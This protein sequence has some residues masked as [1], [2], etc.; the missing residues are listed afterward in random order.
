MYRQPYKHG[1]TYLFIRPFRRLPMRRQRLGE[2][3]D[4]RVVLRLVALV[5]H[6]ALCRRRV[7]G[8]LGRVR[9][10]PRSIHDAPPVVIVDEVVATAVPVALADL[11][12]RRA[13]G[14]LGRR[15]GGVSRRR[16]YGGR[17]GVSS[18]SR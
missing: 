12:A 14:R 17:R 2:L 1:K 13:V 18:S 7:L 10:L 6:E 4:G 9:L 15:R 8:Q 11:A 5:V 16:L 3:R